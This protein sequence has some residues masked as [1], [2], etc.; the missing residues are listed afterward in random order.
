MKNNK[1]I[2]RA[3]KHAELK[4]QYLAQPG[5]KEMLDIYNRWQIAD[6]A[7]QVHQDIKEQS[8]IIANSDNSNS[9]ALF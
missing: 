5:I 3:K 1:T 7:L 8:Y 4:N 9:K 6:K 2:K